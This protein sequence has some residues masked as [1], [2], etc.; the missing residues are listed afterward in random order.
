PLGSVLSSAMMLDHFKMN[1]EAA[2]V[3]EAVKWTLANGCVSK[4]ID[5]INNYSTHEIGDLLVDYI[6]KKAKSGAAKNAVLN[7][8]T[9]I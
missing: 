7:A 9:I 1:D 5:A 6:G 4:D 2:A 8:S 3:R